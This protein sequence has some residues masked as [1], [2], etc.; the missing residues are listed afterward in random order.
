MWV[1]PERILRA[2]GRGR[3]AGNGAESAQAKLWLRLG[4]NVRVKVVIRLDRTPV[5]AIKPTPRP[6]RVP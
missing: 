3:K 6:N 5:I 1:G 4:H 2:G